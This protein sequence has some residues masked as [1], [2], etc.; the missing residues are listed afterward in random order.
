MFEKELQAMKAAAVL[1]EQ[2]ILEIYH[3]NFKVEIKS[4]N[5]PVTKADKTADKLIREYLHRL[6]PTYAFL[7]EESKDDKSRLTNDYV[8]IVD[9]VDGTKEFVARDGEF[10]TNIALCYKHEI[11]AGIIHVPTKDF[12]YWA[13]KGKGA[14]LERKGGEP[15]PLKVSNRTKDLRVLISRSFFNEKEK[16]MIEKHHDQIIDVHPL[17][18]ALKFGAIAEGVADLTYRFSPNTK[19]WD[20]A[21][22]VLLVEEAGG[23]V[24]KPDLT[25]YI[26]N[27]EDPYNR[28]GYIVANRIENVLL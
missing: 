1:A 22:G 11:V 4:D 9:P 21:P 15:I 3:T 26:F 5:S 25:K 23:V 7:T 28:E 18:A 16:A 19:E 27:R 12:M 20:I 8:F 14:F 24:V 13:L 2:A 17:G 6:F 10:T